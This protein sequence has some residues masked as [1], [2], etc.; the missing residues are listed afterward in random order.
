MSLFQVQRKEQMSHQLLRWKS[1]FNSSFS[2]HNPFWPLL[3]KRENAACGGVRLEKVKF[4]FQRRVQP[5]AGRQFTFPG[6]TGQKYVFH[7]SFYLCK[8]GKIGSFIHFFLSVLFWPSFAPRAISIMRFSVW[9]K[10]RKK[11]LSS[12]WCKSKY[13]TKACLENKRESDCIFHFLGTS[14]IE[15]FP[16]F[17]VDVEEKP[18]F[19]IGRK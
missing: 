13:N 9:L 11:G 14:C 15:F 7:Y 4:S 2:T 17:Y 19:S 10:A 12:L 6:M 16:L 8:K 3:L 18:I 5:A 1:F